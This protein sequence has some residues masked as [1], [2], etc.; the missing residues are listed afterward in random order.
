MKRLLNT[1]LLAATLSVGAIAGANELGPD[2]L[3]KTTASEVMAI[4]KADKDIQGGN[5]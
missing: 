5:Q 1:L 3:V 2:E 4:I